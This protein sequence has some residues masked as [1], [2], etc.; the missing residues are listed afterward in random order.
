MPITLY[1]I[2]ESPHGRK[3]RLLAAALGLPLRMVPTDPRTGETRSPDFLAKN[4][5]GRVPTLEEGGFI[6]WESSAILKYLAAKRPD[7]V[8]ELAVFLVDRVPAP[9]TGSGSSAA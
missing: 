8:W 5:N 3:V 2:R 4:P 1:D 7:W 6:L 9:P